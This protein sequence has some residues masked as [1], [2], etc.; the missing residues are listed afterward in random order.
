MLEETERAR[1]L[2]SLRLVS[3]SSGTTAPR[4][5]SCGLAAPSAVLCCLLRHKYVSQRFCVS[6]I[7][8]LFVCFVDEEYMGGE[9][10]LA[11]EGYF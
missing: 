2:G 6:L 7:Y 1:L 4:C 8:I 11:L 5:E 9:N 10:Q 3:Q